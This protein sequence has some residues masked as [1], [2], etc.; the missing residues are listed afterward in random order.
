MRSSSP[1]NASSWPLGRRLQRAIP[2]AILLL[3]WGLRLFRLG[4]ANVWWDEALAVG[5]VR[6]GLLGATLWTA[7][8]V[9]PPLFFWTLWGWVQ[10]V[11]ES[12]FAMRLLP[13]AF[14]VLTVAAVYALGNLVGGRWAGAVGA[15][16]TAV[17]RF[18][19]W[20]SQELR[21]YALAGLLGTL[22]LYFLIRWLRA[23]Q[24]EPDTGTAWRLLVPW[25]LT[26]VGALYTIFLMAA[27][28]VAENLIVLIAVVRQP[29]RWRPMLA[30]W[31]PA[32]L[33]V[34]APVIAWLAVSWGRMSTWSVAEPA[35]LGFVSRLYATLL[36]TGIS[37]NIEQVSPWRI[38]VPMAILAL[39]V[40]LYL[41]RARRFR[42]ARGAGAALE[43]I[44][45]LAACVLPAVAVW[46]ATQ[47]RSLFYT[48]RVEARYLLPFAPAFWALLGIA[49]AEIGRRAR[50]AGIATGLVLVALTAATL[51]GHYSDRVLRDELQ[52]M[53]RAVLS[54]AVPGDVVLLDSGSRYPIYDYYYGGTA[55]A[56]ERPP[57]YQVPPD[58]RPMSA[59][60]LDAMLAP[61]LAGGG[62]VWLAEV[63]ANL[64]DP[65]RLTR[66]WLDARYPQVL[67][68]GYGYNALTLYDPA[69]QAP[70]LNDW[71]PQHPE[72][73]RLAG[74][75]LRGWELPVTTYA[76]GDALHLALLWD[77][78]PTE[79]V[80]LLLR[81]ALGRAV[82]ATQSAAPAQGSGAG[83]S[84]RQQ[85][86]LTVTP[87]VP[88]GTLLVVLRT[89]A[90]QTTLSQVRIR[91]GVP[92]APRV[93]PI[94]LQ[95]TFGGGLELQG[96]R[97]SA[98][99]VAPGETLTLDLYWSAAEPEARDLVAFSHLLGE[100]WN[101]ATQGPV[102]AG[103]DA[104]PNDGGLPVAL[105]LPEQVVVDRHLLTVDPAAPEGTYRLEVGLY[106]AGD[107]A[108]LSAS[109]EGAAGDY[110]LLPIEVRVA[111]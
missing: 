60:R 79:P 16:L 111:R 30:A 104:R 5:A 80:T 19:V 51:P 97:L 58:D 34:A 69:G 82:L 44:G 31:V 110:V 71:A 40:G 1:A 14:G 105:W 78:A 28:L 53:V 20:W 59:E 96:A 72:N 85:L 42:G 3:A 33:A 45:L 24:K 103:H 13:A 54:Q 86:D 39:G 43:V 77:E 22:S 15:L 67:A 107:G 27:L 90:E 50:P 83:V 11:G 108:R 9:H 48:P 25:A 81:D 109:G 46:A 36:T 95:A 35:S 98:E 99:R 56:G 64:T 68:L 49:T 32:Q 55:S 66:A 73:L 37:T 17:A 84:L 63:D 62:R 47:P 100:A 41:A 76:A 6:K 74:G 52:T 87:A 61:W 65:D 18:H 93:P 26:M 70:A 21:M 75:R 2:V 101:P 29:A 102:W 7:S 94:P 106:T 8:D 91:R 4:D 89:G 38:L 12:E 88:S 23:V 92:P 57:V 10:A